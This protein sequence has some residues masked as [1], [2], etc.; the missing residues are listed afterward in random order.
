MERFLK[1]A[2]YEQVIEVFV[3]VVFDQTKIHVRFTNRI[4]EPHDVV[5]HKWEHFFKVVF[6]EE[7][8]DISKI[9]YM[10]F[11]LPNWILYKP[12]VVHERLQPYFA[13]Y[14]N[15]L[16]LVAKESDIRKGDVEAIN[17]WIQVLKPYINQKYQE[18]FIYRFITS[19][20]SRKKPKTSDEI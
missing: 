5:F 13:Y 9:I 12:I 15:N 8:Y 14:I 20:M 18:H 7:F 19:S 10:P 17:Q 11:H 2:L 1:V 4:N 16:L 6:D 3:E